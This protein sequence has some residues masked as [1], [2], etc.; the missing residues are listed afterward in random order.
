MWRS[1]ASAHLIYKPREQ[2]WKKEYVTVNLWAWNFVIHFFL[3]INRRTI[4]IDLSWTGN[5][6][7]ALELVLI[8][9][10]MKTYASNFIDI[11]CVCFGRLERKRE[12]KFAAGMHFPCSQSIFPCSW[13]ENQSNAIATMRD[14]FGCV[15]GM[16]SH[17]VLTAFYH[18]IVYRW[19]WCAGFSSLAIKRRKIAVFLF[20]FRQLACSNSSDLKSQWTV[21]HQHT[22][23]YIYL[24]PYRLH[25]RAFSK[26]SLSCSFFLVHSE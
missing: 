20:S 7:P 15:S 26:I 2:N 11:G 21:T 9:L 13:C 10:K 4:L 14:S 19:I 22:H 24:T 1:K 8:S 16:P 12:G 17:V 5:N 23:T 25:A 18:Q 3:F 6:E